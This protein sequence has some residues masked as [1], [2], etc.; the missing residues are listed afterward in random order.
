MRHLFEGRERGVLATQELLFERGNSRGFHES[1]RRFLSS[2]GSREDGDAAEVGCFVFVL[3]CA[4]EWSSVRFFAGN[5]REFNI[6][7]VQYVG[8]SNVF[9]DECVVNIG[10][11]K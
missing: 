9:R 3:P 5:A 4:N 1:R 6:T 8:G 10:C 2:S 11:R 7:H